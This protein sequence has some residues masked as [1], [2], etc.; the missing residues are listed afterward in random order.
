MGE[1]MVAFALILGRFDWK[2]VAHELGH[3]FG[4]QHDFNDDTYIMVLWKLSESIIRL[5]C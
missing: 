4:L 2:L 3:A 1:K 5:Q